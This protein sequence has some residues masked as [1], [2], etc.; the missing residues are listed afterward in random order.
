MKFNAKRALQF[1][2]CDKKPDDKT[3]DVSAKQQLRPIAVDDKAEPIV[4]VRGGKRW[5]KCPI[6]ART[7]RKQDDFEEHFMRHQNQSRKRKSHIDQESV[8][9]TR[10]AKSNKLV[11]ANPSVQVNTHQQVLFRG[12][13]RRPWLTYMQQE[14]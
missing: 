3:V 4:E 5:L 10:L 8:D 14:E 2:N 12:G 1:H 7:Y 6:C 13:G 9:S 11:S